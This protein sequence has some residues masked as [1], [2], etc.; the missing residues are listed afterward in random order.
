MDTRKQQLI[1][2]FIQKCSMALQEAQKSA[3]LNENF[4]KALNNGEVEFQFLKKDGTIRDAIGT[5][6][7]GCIPP[8]LGTGKPLPFDLQLYFDIEK[9]S[10]RSFR[11][12]NL[13]S[14]TIIC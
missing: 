5:M 1:E 13:I 11:K 2:H 12:E 9:G 6:K 8:I 7:H 3:E 10:F 4:Y 14:F